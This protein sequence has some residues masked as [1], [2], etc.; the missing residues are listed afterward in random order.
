[1]LG[2]HSGLQT[3]VAIATLR[4]RCWNRGTL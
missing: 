4:P 3:D 2:V 1:M